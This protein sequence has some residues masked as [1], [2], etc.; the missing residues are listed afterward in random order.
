MD[1]KGKIINEVSP[2]IIVFCKGKMKKE[3][4]L[5]SNDMSAFKNLV[6]SIQNNKG[7][8]PF[9]IIFNE[10]KDSETLKKELSYERVFPIS[11]DFLLN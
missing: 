10:E 7:L 3:K 1:K 9:V 6:E 2:S 4:R 8:A 11:K 5:F